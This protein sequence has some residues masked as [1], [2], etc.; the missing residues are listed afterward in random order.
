MQREVRDFEPRI[1]LDG[2]VD[3][4]D[5]YRRIAAKVNRY[6]ARGGMLILECGEN[7][8]QEIIKIF[9]QSS[10]CDY[11]MVVRDLNGIERVIKI[12]F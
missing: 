5:F 7:Q 12:G 8:A 2:G 1:A 6:I 4:L 11:A 3:G 9:N 10:R